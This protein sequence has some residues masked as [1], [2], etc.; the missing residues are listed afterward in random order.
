M[1]FV[2]FGDHTCRFSRLTSDLGTRIIPGSRIQDSTGIPRIEPRWVQSPTLLQPLDSAK[3]QKNQA[4]K[5]DRNSEFSQNHHNQGYQIVTFW[6]GSCGSTSTATSIRLSWYPL[7]APR[8]CSMSIFL[9]FVTLVQGAGFWVGTTNVS[10]LAHLSM[11]YCTWRTLVPF[12]AS[13]IIS[14]NCQKWSLTPGLKKLS[15]STVGC[16]SNFL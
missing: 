16:S 9:W 10:T 2:L 1:H 7:T 15:L 12:L 8:F 13:H 6:N 4:Q 3:E 5:R 14:W 11:L